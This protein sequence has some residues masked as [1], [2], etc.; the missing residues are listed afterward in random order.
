MTQPSLPGSEV[1]A[2]KGEGVINWAGEGEKHPKT[3]GQGR[4]WSGRGG[5]LGLFHG[6]MKRLTSPSSSAQE[7]CERA[8]G[9]MQ[10][11]QEDCWWASM[12]GVNVASL[13]T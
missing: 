3:T 5:L 7:A 12:V 1:G 4:M 8:K 9:R 13:G 11:G 6:G 10:E 2:S